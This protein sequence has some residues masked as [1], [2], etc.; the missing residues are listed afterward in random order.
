MTDVATARDSDESTH[1]RPTLNIDEHTFNDLDVF[2][3][4]AQAPSL[5]GLCNLTRSEGGARALRQ[6]MQNPMAD[7]ADILA[8]Q[9]SITLIG[10]NPS[11]FSRL[12]SLTFTAGRVD[13]YM[14]EIL[15]V[16]VHEHPLD[17]TVEA[18]GVWHNNDRHYNSI[19]TGVQVTVKFV[20]AVRN[21]INQSEFEFVEG[22]LGVLLA[23]IDSLLTQPGL[24]TIPR[25]DVGS[26]FWRILRLDQLFRLQQKAT[27]SRLLTLIYD[28]DALVAMAQATRK[29]GWILPEIL[30]GPLLVVAEALY[31]PFVEQAAV[32]P[33]Q[34]DQSH[35]LLFLTGP[36]MAGK[37]TYLR[38][39]A[40]AIYL[41]HLGLGVPA[42]QFRFVP[43]AY[44]FSSISLNDDLIGGV[45]YFRAEALRVKAIAEAVS[46]GG[47]V[48]AL[49]DEPFKGTN[50]K[51]ALDAS[52]SVME[53]LADKE[54][55][56]FLFSSH[57]IELSEHLG[58]HPQVDCRFFEADESQ[59]QLLF[60]YQ[61]QQGVSNQRLGMRV[62]EEEGIFDLLR[63]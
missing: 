16:V 52:L 56:L 34:L 40:T 11:A 31:H 42:Q 45:S 25:Q 24:S 21:F 10:N 3:K 46:T 61:L 29:H 39:I 30:D 2:T 15:P 19:V 49:M 57:L 38:S 36:N 58:E 43:A 51:D 48:I 23:E 22:E 7:S 14:H 6:R 4:D 63:D 28:I 12:G 32:N 47:R 55:C 9:Q 62:L 41:A 20:H 33:V 5:F 18:L 37:T 27:I 1:I 54:D 26:W 60:D 59:G 50:V 8:T 53:R 44:L 13:R 35:R 17:F